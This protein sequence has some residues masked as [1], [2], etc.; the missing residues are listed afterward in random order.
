MNALLQ[1]KTALVTGG[2]RRVG[3]A[4]CRRLHAAGANMVVHCN[5]SQDD[6]QTLVHELNGPRPGSAVLV[7]ADLLGEAATLAPGQIVDVPL[8]SL[9]GT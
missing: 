8:A 6:A 4:I 2:A 5:R 7:Q 9:G 1:D 3:A